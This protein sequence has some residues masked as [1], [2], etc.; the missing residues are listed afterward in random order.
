[1]VCGAVRHVLGC[2]VLVSEGYVCEYA[3]DAVPGVYKPTKEHYKFA[4]TKPERCPQAPQ[5]AT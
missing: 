2:A 3:G 4:S 1:M 5:T